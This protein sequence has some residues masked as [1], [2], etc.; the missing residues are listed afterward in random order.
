MNS[1]KLQIDRH[2]T[3][4]ELLDVDQDAVIAALT[5]LNRN[6]SRLKNPMLRKILAKRVS[7]ADACA[8]AG[9]SIPDF[10]RSMQAIGFSLSDTRHDAPESHESSF[11][12]PDPDSIVELDVRPTLAGGKDPLKQILQQVD[13]LKE[14]EV[15][16]LTNSFEPLPLITLLS[17]QG[18]NFH[19]EHISKEVVVTWFFRST[20]EACQYAGIEEV[21]NDGNTE[22]DSFLQKYQGK[23]ITLDVRM[24][25][26]P[27]P[28]L[29]ILEALESLPGNKALFIHHKK[30][31]VYLLENLKDKN[32]RCLIKEIDDNNVDLLIIRK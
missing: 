17:K 18:F 19:V 5:A 28:M 6:F 12:Q 26:M 7:V 1:G 25:E 20:K 11:R 30:I 13:K 8:I 21:E 3:I 4:K 10:F 27:Q 32:F 14:T 9:C 2:T 16:K 24:L 15:L 31:P 23:L 22:F 29:T